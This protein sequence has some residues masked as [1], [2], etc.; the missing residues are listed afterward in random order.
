LTTFGVLVKR[1]ITLFFSCR[2][3][4]PAFSVLLTLRTMNEPTAASLPA[5]PTFLPRGIPVAPFAMQKIL[6]K[7]IRSHATNQNLHSTAIKAPDKMGGK[8]GS[9]RGGRGGRGARAGGKAV[10]GAKK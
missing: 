5:L 2:L 10:G 8:R 9:S 7:A 6:T 1:K 4:T 3:T